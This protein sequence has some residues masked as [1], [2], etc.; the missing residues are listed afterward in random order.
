MSSVDF[1]FTFTCC[2]SVEERWVLTHPPEPERERVRFR[3]GE[4]MA[5]RERDRQAAVETG[6]VG[7]KAL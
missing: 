2:L 6:E 5:E 4:E 1:N 3:G 7:R